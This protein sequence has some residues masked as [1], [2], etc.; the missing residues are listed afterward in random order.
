MKRRG[1]DCFITVDAR[2]Y[3]WKAN[4]KPSGALKRTPEGLFSL[5][6]ATGIEPVTP[7]VSR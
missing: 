5:V 3:N 2:A 6:G 4:I 1:P 7:T